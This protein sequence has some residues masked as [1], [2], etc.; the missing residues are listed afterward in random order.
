MK[1]YN[2]LYQK[3]YEMENL[4]MAHKN[5]RKCKTHYKEVMRIDQNPAK[6]LQSLHLILKEKKFRNSEYTHITRTMK[7]GK[8]RKIA[9]LPYYPDR[10]V[11]HAIIQVVGDIWKKSFINNTYACIKGRGIH[12]C[13][14]KIKR[15]LINR[16]ATRYC[17]K[18]DVKQFYPSVNHDVLKMIIRKKIKD[19][20]LLWLLDL[21][22]DSERGLPIGNYLSQFLG[23]LYL[24][25]MDHFIK[26]QLHCHYYYR[27]CD[28]MVILSENKRWLHDIRIIL[29]SRLNA[30]HLEL[31]SNWQVFPVASRGIDFLGYRFFHGYTLLRK[32]I[33]N[34]IKESMKE[35]K[36]KWEVMPAQTVISRV[37]SYYG[38][39]H[40]SNCRNLKNKHIDDEIF[41]IV[42]Q[43]AKELGVANPLQG[44][45]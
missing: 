11:H 27:Y 45:A 44:V 33:A 26:E 42:K 19:K 15:D 17:L 12:K 32:S 29:E 7:S 22:I 34:G 4:L 24:S 38:W 30:I 5:A 18:M 3:V 1:R 39:M 10:I 21:I 41:W 43:K 25:E 16:E 40:Y 14:R 20:D 13:V 35:V 6:H 37:M 36:Q 8:V 31:K 23:N 2:N 28:D 9:K